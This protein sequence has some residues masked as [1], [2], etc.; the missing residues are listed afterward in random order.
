MKQDEFK[1]RYI[2]KLA[3]SIVLAALNMIVQ[4]ILPR[5]FTVEEYGYYSYNLNVFT[6]VV[7]IASLSVPSALCAKFSK[8]NEETG[9]IW[10]YLKFYLAMTLVLNLAVTILYAYGFLQDTFAGQTLFTVLL[11]MEASIILR[12]H[13]DSIGIFDA[14]A[15]S[16]FPAVM[17]TV[18]KAAMSAAVI[19][20][21]LA[22]RLN[23]ACFYVIQI[24]LT[25]VITFCMLHEIL[26]DQKR[27]Y[28]AGTD[29]G[30]RAYLKEFWVF[31]RPLVMSNAVSQFLVIFMNWSLMHWSG[32]SDQAM[33][34][35]AWQLN[36]LVS[37]VFSPY[38][39]LSKREFAVIQNDAEG[40]RHR[41]VQSL[42][43]M[44][45]LTSYFAVFT[46][47]ASAWLLPVV[48]GEKYADAAFVTLLIMFYTIYQAWGQIS[49]SFLL[50]VER[51]KL[52]AAIGITSQVITLVLVF[53]FQI[54]NA[55]WPDGLG[56]TGIALTY[57][58]ANIL[59][60]S[61]SLYANAKVLK[62]DFWRNWS[63]QLLPIALCSM[64]M[65]CLKYGMDYVL[66]EN[67]IIVLAVKT[68]AAGI[69]Y[70]AAVGTVL[71][72]NPQFIGITKENLKMA[73]R[74]ER[75][76]K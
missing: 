26:R 67:S 51:T 24:L 38:A 29:R 70:T 76:K 22:G 27:R 61:I 41:Y 75:E 5:V 50:A 65:L 68:V 12:L 64:I 69:V 1:N 23:L 34:G 49:G 60:V 63:I 54:P 9:L 72:R 44:M 20:S 52:S 10:F 2:I 59:N 48:Y 14:M 37:Y 71:Y 21:F 11:G 13:T 33:F 19:L 18:L 55:I 3:S 74:F 7:G 32:A 8:R 36:T 30:G 25:F 16:R 73:V 6:A 43:L 15:V 57:L 53:L 35:A 58:A 28:P 4:L 46:G 47:F 40:L 17:Q 31:C 56:S 45:W 42:R 66:D 62:M 39:E